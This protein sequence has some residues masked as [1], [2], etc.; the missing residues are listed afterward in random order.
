MT[1]QARCTQ[2]VLALAMAGIA[3]V[4]CDAEV[5]LYVATGGNDAWSGR[6]AAPNSAKTDGP[7]AT[8]T[9]ARDLIRL[10]QQRGQAATPMR[11]LVREGTY[12][13]AEPLVL[14]PEDSGTA[15]NPVSYAAFP[16]EK[17]VLSGGRRVVGPWRA[18]NN[19]Y[20]TEIPEVRSG[21]WFF[22]QLRADDCLQVRARHPNYDP[23]QPWVR[24]LSIVRASHG[25]FGLFMGQLQEIG[26]WLEYA[27]EAPAQGDYTIRIY[28]ANNGKTNQS[29]SGKRDISGESAISVDSGPL[30]PLADMDDTGSFYSGFR[31][32]RSGKVSLTR[33]KH[34]LRWVN[35]KGCA[36][37][38]DA[39]LLTQDP[40][41]APPAD[42][43][44]KNAPKPAILIQAERY[45][46]KH[47][48]KPIEQSSA[49]RRD[50]AMRTRLEF[51]AGALRR[52]DRSPDAEVFLIPEYDWVSEI[53]RLVQVDE[54]AQVARLQGA[55]A[56]K[57]IFGG[58]RFYAANVLE[59]LDQP[60]EWCLQRDT[61]RLHWRPASG[62]PE[63]H[64]VV[65]PYLERVIE[66]RGTVEHPVRHLGLC[67]FAISDTQATAPERVEDVYFPDDAAVVLHA[68]TQCR[69]EK[70]VFRQVGGYGVMLTGA[71][72]E[73]TI[74][75]N[76]VHEAGQGGIYLNGS[77]GTPRRAA[78][79]GNRPARNRI[80]GNY[81]HHCGWMYVHVAGVQLNHAEG[82]LV[83][84]NL[85]HDVPRYGIS[86]KHNCPDNT[87]EYNEVRRT[88]LATRDSGAI[89]M[90]EN[91]VGSIVRGNL[92]VDAVGCGYDVAAG[93]VR[94][95]Q[96]ACGIYLDNVSS[97]VQVVGNI[98]A[99]CSS[100]LWANWGSDNV[101][102]DN[103]FIDPRDCH[104]SFTCS[105]DHKRPTKGNSLQRNVFVSRRA[106][107]PVYQWWAWR[108]G[109]AQSDYNLFYCAGRMPIVKGLPG[110][111]A[112]SWVAWQKAGQDLHSVVADPRLAE[113]ASGE[114]RLDPSS[115]A[116]QLGC[117]P[118]EFR[119][120][121]LRGYRPSED[122]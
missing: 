71:S 17:V 32:S 116:A 30:V 120:I 67:G 14:G 75:G 93:A 122:P 66:L 96:D 44:Q 26:T 103:L 13:L 39:I 78:P 81:V 100:G 79:P 98:V 106:D 97:R 95:P 92:V 121:G 20:W 35:V 62:K 107:L 102:T 43:T 64:A 112:A 38:L 15:V 94:S 24:G 68:A 48:D 89:E 1:R 115:P 19:V 22:R 4:R 23:Q 104:L 10:C 69:L 113:G 51:S 31:W 2:L 33:G 12:Y 84:N 86:L 40:D 114:Y 46:R 118:A 6:L 65:A 99:R 73:N 88:N 82:N 119:Q 91:M 58:N 61:G 25:G 5:T 28:Y 80:L 42:G 53:L 55:N 52:W 117:R 29:R 70:C 47:G 110:T 8:L 45:E 41:C 90:A 9:Q 3:A 74:A 72:T 87:V 109:A 27:I 111:P 105:P 21:R 18:E 11:V 7:L 60:G 50:P 37:S 108:A 49:D 57:A 83:A 77:A 54:A 56:Q 101:I 76:E 34:T 16:G 63:S 85:I 36:L 59:A